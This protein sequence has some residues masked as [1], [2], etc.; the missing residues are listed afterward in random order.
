MIVIRLTA[1]DSTRLDYGA[2]QKTSAIRGIVGINQRV[3]IHFY[4]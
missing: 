3:V 1:E 2:V 4:P